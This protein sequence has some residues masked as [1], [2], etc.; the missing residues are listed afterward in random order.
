MQRG[1]TGFLNFHR[2]AVGWSLVFHGIIIFTLFISAPVKSMA[3]LGTI[4][5][6]ILA[7]SSQT[8]SGYSATLPQQTAFLRHPIPSPA[9]KTN[10]KRPQQQVM[11]HQEIEKEI[12]YSV[13]DE[14]R[15]VIPADGNEM[16]A[17]TSVGLSADAQQ[18]APAGESGFGTQGVGFAGE[19]KFGQA[20]APFF[21]YQAIPAYPAQA[22]RL[23][24]EGRVVLKLL[25]DA[26]GELVHIEVVESAGY[27]FTEAS[28]AAV[29][30]STYAPGV[31]NGVK[32][33]TR[34][35][36]PISFRLQ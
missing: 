33:A 10:T 2:R 18:N 25:I 11:G 19:T 23:G 9:K 4:F 24:M 34:A 29:K 35:L 15:P 28:I 26:N 12:S 1:Q 20:G 21:L 36:L 13:T 30:K 14:L 7:P 22:R 8:E 27:G 5:V 17:G 31:R 32:V 6:S 16:A 3:S